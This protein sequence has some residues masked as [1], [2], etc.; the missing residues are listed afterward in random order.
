[1]AKELASLIIAE[2][3]NHELLL[4]KDSRRVRLYKVG[5][6]MEVFV[7]A[8]DEIAA[9]SQAEC[10][11]ERIGRPTKSLAEVVPFGIRGWSRATF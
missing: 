2:G 7:L 11:T 3:D 9:I 4:K 5:V 6:A 8:E 1:M 10:I